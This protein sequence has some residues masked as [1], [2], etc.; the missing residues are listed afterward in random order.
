[1]RSDHKSVVE[2]LMKYGLVKPQHKIN[3]ARLETPTLFLMACCLPSRLK[4][5]DPDGKRQVASSASG[6][7]CSWTWQPLIGSKASHDPGD[8]CQ[9]NANDPASR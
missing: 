3:K 2:T 7:D 6:S 9:K 5:T 1:M 4:V 8:P